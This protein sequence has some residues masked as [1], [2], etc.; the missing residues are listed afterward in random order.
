MKD[1]EN[2]LVIPDGKIAEFQTG[3]NFR[4][5]KLIAHPIK[6]NILSN[7]AIDALGYNDTTPGPVI[8]V[9]QDEWVYLEVENRMDHP[10]A[11]HVH[12]LPKPNTEDGNPA[13]EPTP[14]IQPGQ[15]YTYKFQAWKSGTFFYHSTHDFQS[16]LGLVGAFIVLPK[17][18]YITQDFIPDRDFTLF[19]QQ[20]QIE[21]PELGKVVPGVY[22]PNKFDLQPNFFTL[23][24]KSFPT[25]TP[26]NVRLGEKVRVR[27][28]N[29]TSSPHSMHIHGHSF[30]VVEVD[31]FKRKNLYDDTISL[32]SGKR[33]DVEFITNNPGIWPVN[34]TRTFH[35]SNNGEALGGMVTRLTYTH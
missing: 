34:G 29:K 5:F 20:W 35:Q 27:F 1:W 3:Q 21:Q 4:Y 23:N 18:E 7:V 11:L 32:A 33:K 13:I 17:Q 16:N 24:G 9:N 12:G 6:H 14:T 22:K 10:T 19:V 28:I 25:T 15:S 26:M 30:K 2:R 8:V 31:G